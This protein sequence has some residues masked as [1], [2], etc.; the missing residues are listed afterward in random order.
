MEYVKQVDASHYSFKKYFYP[1]RWMSYWHQANEISSRSDIGA[2]LDVGPGTNF[3]ADVLKIH[4]PDIKY[5]TLDIA[6]DVAP[7]YVGSV[8]AIP[9]Q[10]KSFDAVCAFQVLEHIKFEDFEIALNEIKRVT[11]K[12]A[13]IS[14]PHFGPSV[15]FQLKFP[16]LPRVKVAFKIP[17]Y[18]KH[19]FG[20][21]HY[22][23]IGKRGYSTRVVRKLIAEHFDIIDEYVPF[24]NQYHR[25]FILK[26][27]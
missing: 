4:R 20:G 24:E 8:T 13:F 14:L 2:V 16:F 25:F 11:K 23:E 22:W 17:F 19:S 3:L 7:D 21:Q 27:K 1:G 12:Y 15:E 26:V 9:L 18:Q 6:E 5:S 10:D